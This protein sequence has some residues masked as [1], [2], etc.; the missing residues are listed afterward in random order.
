M[1]A[2]FAVRVGGGLVTSGTAAEDVG[3]SGDAVAGRNACVLIG[4][5]VQGK[6][7]LGQVRDSLG[8]L[9]VVSRK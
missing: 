2:E 8:A 3:T 4:M 7:G 6:P 1:P 5:I 9:R